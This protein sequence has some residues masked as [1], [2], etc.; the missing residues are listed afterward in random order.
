MSSVWFGGG[1]HRDELASCISLSSKLSLV[2][3]HAIVTAVPR[4]AREA[5]PNED[6]LFKSVFVTSAIILLIKASHVVK[7]RVRACI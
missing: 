3:I 5:R 4:T 6:A 7:P 1:G 2:C